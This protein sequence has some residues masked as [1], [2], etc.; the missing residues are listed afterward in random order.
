ML[1]F[2]YFIL[3][4]LR[5]WICGFHRHRR[6]EKIVNGTCEAKKVSMERKKIFT[7]HLICMYLHMHSRFSSE[8]KL[9]K[10]ANIYTFFITEKQVLV[11]YHQ[12]VFEMDWD[13]GQ[14]Q[15][16]LARPPK[17]MEV[18]S[19][20][21]IKAKKTDPLTNWHQN[22]PV[23][24]RR[25]RIGILNFKTPKIWGCVMERAQDVSSKVS[26]SQITTC[27]QCWFWRSN[28]YIQTRK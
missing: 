8:I 24:T 27:A 13:Q 22:K 26:P 2:Y 19:E 3:L 10:C 18:W 15:N 12:E 21:P 14:S 17:K 11:D 1:Q 23:F 6:G 16:S 20:N 9:I 28:F 25:L 4:Y 7:R 5:N